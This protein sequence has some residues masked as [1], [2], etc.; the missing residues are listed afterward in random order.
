MQ[1][2]DESIIAVTKTISRKVQV[3]VY[4][5][6]FQENGGVKERSEEF[7][8]NLSKYGH[9]WNVYDFILVLYIKK[10]KYLIKRRE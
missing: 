7:N 2:D 10:H 8:L 1:L 4:F 6:E 9:K 5:F 3:I